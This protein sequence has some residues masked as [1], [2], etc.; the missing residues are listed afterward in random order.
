[1][2]GLRDGIGWHPPLIPRKLTREDF[3]FTR[4]QIDAQL[5]Q[6]I[7]KIQSDFNDSA[8]GPAG[9]KN[10]A[11]LIDTLDPTQHEAFAVLGA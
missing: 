3:S 8:M 11:D 4:E 1:M 9:E 2:D 7:Q 10:L 6:A 5:E